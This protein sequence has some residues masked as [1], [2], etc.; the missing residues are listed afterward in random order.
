M[1]YN[2]SDL[3]LLIADDLDRIISGLPGSDVVDQIRREIKRAISHYSAYRFGFNETTRNIQTV[4]GQTYLSSSLSDVIALDD[5]YITIGSRDVKMTEQPLDQ[6]IEERPSSNGTPYEYAWFN[7]RI[8]LEVPPSTTFSL[9]AYIHYE[10]PELSSDTDQNG[11]TNE[12]Q[13]L[14]RHRAEKILYANVLK[15]PQKAISSA[16]LEKDSLNALRAKNNRRTGG[17]RTCYL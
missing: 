12:G 17:K 15:D 2:Y 13:D 6:I 4:T 5:L 11:W 3:Q 1:S 14:I 9:T 10:L 16:A 8:E 7:N